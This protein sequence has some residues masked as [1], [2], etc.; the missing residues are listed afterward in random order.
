MMEDPKQK[1]YD[2]IKEYKKEIENKTKENNEL[3]HKLANIEIDNKNELEAQTEYLNNMIE[4]YKKNIENMKEQKT[5]AAKDFKEQN[6]KLE[7]EI[8]NYKCQIASIQFEMDR[9]LVT[10]KKYVKK[11]QTKLESLGFKFKDKNSTKNVR[12]ALSK[13]KTIV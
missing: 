6:E 5:K 8:G 11:L 13:S 12:E 9:K 4:G 2:E 10:Y 1:L 3:K 7:I